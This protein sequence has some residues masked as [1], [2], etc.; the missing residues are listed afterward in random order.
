[1]SRAQGVRDTA[2]W[3]YQLGMRIALAI[4]AVVLVIVGGAGTLV[5]AH[6]ANR[7]QEEAR[8]RASS[9]LRTLAV[10]AAMAVAE[11]AL[12]RLDGYLAEVARSGGEFD[13]LYIA[14]VDAEGRT[15]AWSTGMTRKLPMDQRAVAPSV[16]FVQ[17]A[18]NQRLPLWRERRADGELPVLWLSMPAV[19]GLRWGTVV[20]AFDVSRQAEAIAASQHL[21]M[22]ATVLLTVFLG[23]V[24]WLGL[25]YL[26]VQPIRHLDQTARQLEAGQRNA[27]A[28]LQREDEIGRFAKVFD[29]LA[30]QAARSIEDLERRVAERSAEVQRKN[31]QL[32]EVNSRLEHANTELDRLAHLDPLTAIPNRRS[33]AQVM[34][35][36]L[37]QAGPTC[38][39]MLDIDHFKR[40]NDRFGHPVGDAVL[41][42]FALVLQG[43]LRHHDVLARYGGEEFVAVLPSTDPEQGLEIAER[44]RLAVAGHD[45]S[46]AAEVP[47]GPLTLSAGLACFPLDAVAP[48]VLVQRA[49]EALY[50][51]KAGGRNQV[52]C[53]GRDPA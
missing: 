25:L 34:T 32:Q 29:N 33:F 35:R 15:I 24:A 4:A 11:H 50:A 17:D 23:G 41:R 18:T 27:R 16:T 31:E 7:Q 9:L 14:M 38:L 39:I 45:F 46:V 10:P 42:E 8:A 40:L 3:R 6:Q 22:L 30:E 52:R 1:M 48:D 36:T 37:Q 26:V 43:A 13:V 2:P 5:V 19:S 44:L 20:A 12:E 21:W 47:V 49:D 51:A 28:N 53:F